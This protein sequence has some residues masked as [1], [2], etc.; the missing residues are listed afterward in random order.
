MADAFEEDAE[1]TVS[2]GE[3]LQDLEEQELVIHL[4]IFDFFHVF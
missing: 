4:T 2:I 3:Y 1:H